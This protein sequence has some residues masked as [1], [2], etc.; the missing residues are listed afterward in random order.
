MTDPTEQMI[1]IL[2]RDGRASYSEIA[3]ELNSNREYVASRIN[4]L[5]ETGKLRIVAGVHPRI[6]GLS[7]AA[8]LSVRVGGNVRRVVDAIN[9]LPAPDLISVVVGSFQIVVELQL[10]S[11]THLRQEVATI[12]ALEG[13][14]EVHVLLYERVLNSFFDGNEPEV[15]GEEL[16]ATDVAIIQRLANDGRANFAEIAESV[17]LSL[18]GC[19]T[20]VQRL[21]ESHVMHVGAIKQRADMANDLLFGIGANTRDGDREVIELLSAQPGLEFLGRTVGRFD[22]LATVGFDSLSEFNGLVSTLRS[23][24][25]VTDCEQWLH[26]SLVRERY[27]QTLDWLRTLGGGVDQPSVARPQGAPGQRPVTR[28][29][30]R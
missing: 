3:R 24:P 20:R 8:H 28:L 29:A 13:V 27:E 22:L 30:S 17:G 19:R 23:L 18:S 21:I 5:I 7:V 15:L 4:P 2:R 26:V 10:R 6:L 14:R 9:A 1:A 25:S 16:D 12:R 11:L